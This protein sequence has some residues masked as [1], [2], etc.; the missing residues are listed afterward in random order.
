MSRPRQPGEEP[1]VA[2]RGEDTH[3]CNILL[4]YKRM[5][6]HSK[7]ISLGQSG[8]FFSEKNASG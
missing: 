6:I 4:Y 7:I 5:E 1:P 3:A 8:Y 2:M